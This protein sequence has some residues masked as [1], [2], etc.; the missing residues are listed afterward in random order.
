MAGLLKV[1]EQV[2]LPLPQVSPGCGLLSMTLPRGSLERLPH[3]GQSGGSSLRMPL[4][5][6]TPT[7]LDK[8]AVPTDRFTLQSWNK[9]GN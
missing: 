2:P 8:T 3:V 4:L 9:G 1:K 6:Q 7:P 5:P